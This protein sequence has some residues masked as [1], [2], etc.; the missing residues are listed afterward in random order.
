MPQIALL[1]QETIDKIAAGEVIE[2]P[3]SVVK[4]LVENAIDAGSSA[5]TVEIK[6]GGISFIRISDNG[7]GIEREQ[8]P[9]AFLRHST[10]KIKSVED[11]FTVTSLGFRGEA[12]SSI[13][14]VSQ[15]EL[16]TK[17]NGD[18]TG[19]RYLIEGSKE[20]SLEEIGAPDGTTF[21]IRNLFYNT[22]ARKKFLKSAQTEGTYI[23][24]LMQRMILS[25]PD[26]AF[27]FIM[28][29]QVKLQ[30]SGNGNIKDIIY[31]L[32]GRD[33]TKALLPIAHES[34][35]FKVSGFI[36]KPMI[37]RGN[38]G[39]ELY[40]VNGRFI[41]SQILSK[42][43]EDA[44][45][46]FLMQH[47]Y[48]FTVLYF[49]I[50]SSLLDVNVHPTKMEL[51]FS[52]QQEL[53]RE[54]QSILSAALVHRDIIPEVPVDTPKKNE[55][56]VPKIEKV[57]PEP[58]EQK[59]L[60]EIR[61]AVRKDSPY[62]IKYPVS[63]P[64]GTGSVS[65][66]TQEKLLD[67]IKSMPP[68]GMMEERIR[69]E[70]LPEQSKKETEKELAKEAYVLREEETYGAKPEGSYEQGS[71]LKEEEMAKQKIIGQ[72]FDTY[73]LVE[74][75]D[76]LFIVDQHAA[77]E[78]VMYEKLKKQFEKKE[79]TSQAISPPIVITLSM[80]EAEV[81]ERFKEQFTKLG[82]EIEHFGGAEY[83][84]C[85]V[86]GNLYR[87]NTRDVLIDMLDELTDGISERAT[88]D[89][90]LDK[91]ASMSCKAAVKGSQRLSLPEMEQ[92]MKDLMKLDN[93][94]NCPHGRPTIIAMS[95]YEIEKK[96]KRIV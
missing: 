40:F 33:I 10:S 41:R 2:R 8:I 35:L 24:E 89:V 85:G 19:S 22:P 21:I 70:P 31:H 42:A 68:E 81:L 86:P 53:Y 60:E 55:M 50:D 62:E 59:R 52:N 38:R 72:L 73:W 91:I 66:A 95:K 37:S 61:K 80:R 3:S 57:M 58:F 13:A 14:A 46:P 92:L 56:E 64:M 28:N 29:N 12:L 93:P 32:Y 6:E 48:P 45:K 82:F 96:F 18:F 39:Y 67:T 17:T 36:G 90:I 30:S 77:H 44:F 26:V 9:L 78:K 88:T 87:L 69:K 43:I 75:N 54:V 51:R 7:C 47:Q 11:L 1:S 83:S 63:R 15:V 79:F 94:Y 4:E 49:E 27:K 16:I 5:V 76:R 74:Y 71:F 23:H 20:V 84:I 65:S 25:H 34:E